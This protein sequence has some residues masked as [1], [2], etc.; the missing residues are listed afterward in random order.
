MDI[1]FGGAKGGVTVDPKK[2]SERELEKLTRK[3]VQASCSLSC[4]LPEAADQADTCGT[5]AASGCSLPAHLNMGIL[6]RTF[7]MLGLTLAA[8]LLHG[9]CI[10]AASAC[11]L[12]ALT[13]VGVWQSTSERGM[14]I[15]HSC[16][17]QNTPR[18][19]DC[20]RRY[21][22]MQICNACRALLV[23]QCMPTAG[24]FT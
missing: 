7:D 21:T 22:C 5:L 14:H 8:H 15:T 12:P 10:V 19:A 18:A 17:P 9:C 16:C 3:L 11:C 1:P 24:C 20:R 23:F 13:H 2:L 6:H 4:I